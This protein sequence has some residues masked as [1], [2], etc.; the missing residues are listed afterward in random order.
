MDQIIEEISPWPDYLMLVSDLSHYFEGA[1]KPS[2]TQE[3]DFSSEL[4]RKWETPSWNFQGL[5]I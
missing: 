1:K 4:R 5:V 2:L 3:F